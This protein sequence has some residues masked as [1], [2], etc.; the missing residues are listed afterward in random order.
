M[1]IYASDFTC[2]FQYEVCTSFFRPQPSF[3]GTSLKIEVNLHQLYKG[4]SCYHIMVLYYLHHSNI[5][6]LSYRLNL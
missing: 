5:F 6:Y 1:M 4:Y 3:V 2:F